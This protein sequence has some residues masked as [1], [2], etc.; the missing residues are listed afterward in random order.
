MG[1]VTAI[2]VGATVAA[3]GTAIYSATQKPKAPKMP[4][5]P[6][7]EDAAAKAQAMADERRRAAARFQTVHTSPL[8]LEE[9]AAVAKKKLLGR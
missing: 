4:E 1:L 8:G 3:A 5:P 2:V 9:E 6:K 7:V